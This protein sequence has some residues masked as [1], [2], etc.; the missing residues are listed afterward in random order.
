MK[1]PAGAMPCALF[2]DIPDTERES[3]LT[4][5][6]ATQRVYRNGEYIFMAGAR[7]V[8]VGVVLSGGAWVLQDDFWGHRKILSR[9]HPGG[10]LGEAFS[11]AG[12]DTFPFSVAA[13]E[14]SEVLLIDFPR[15]V[16]TC[17][18]PC[19]SHARLITNLLR[20]LAEKNIQ[21]TRQMEHISRRTTRDKLLSY[22]S[23]QARLS[24][25]NQIEIPL[26]RQELAD[27][28]CVDRCALSREL[29]QLR[30][31]GLFIF[32]KN[33]FELLPRNTAGSAED[34]FC[35]LLTQS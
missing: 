2:A 13:A 29:G 18:I 5:L 15:I 27:Y 11:C 25:K 30:E 24:G 16:T 12:K 33:H 4:C 3:L 17:S 20:L 21:L 8:S 14:N 31:E 35:R 23:S 26:N 1:I 9:I 19:I 28:L 7:P 32:E 6:S 34:P 22:L 10:L